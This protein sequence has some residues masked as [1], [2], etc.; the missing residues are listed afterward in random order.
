MHFLQQ[1]SNY[2]SPIKVIHLRYNSILSH[3]RCVSYLGPFGS[4]Y[5]FTTSHWDFPP[6][7]IS[8]S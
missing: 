1:L 6:L 4:Q 8:C 3:Q 5:Q 7:K 2:H